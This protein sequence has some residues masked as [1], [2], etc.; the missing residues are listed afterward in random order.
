MAKD[1]VAK[2]SLVV[3]EKRSLREILEE[4]KQYEN[5]IK[6]HPD[7]L[8]RGQS[9]SNWS[10]E[11]SLARI[12][13]KKDLSHDKSLQLEREM[14]NKFSIS[15]SKL[16]ELKQT[17]DLSLSRFISQNPGQSIDFPGWFTVMQQYYAPTR[18]LDW[19]SSAMVAAYFACQVEETDGAI[20][21]ADY[22]KITNHSISWIADFNRDKKD[23]E[24]KS[25]TQLM[26][27]ESNMENIV[28]FMHAY[29][30]NERIE[31]QQGFYSICTNLLSDHRIEME[32]INALFKVV[33]PKDCK[34]KILSELYALNINAR[35][36]FPG[37]DGLGK[38]MKEF[39]N[40]WDPNSIIE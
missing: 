1:K 34:L 23:S 26:F 35:T 21:I 40:L 13:K 3:N 16:L 6:L 14:V 28:S 8:F 32:K 5:P 24:K 11:P 18:C 10:L 20:W 12:L 15:A 37:I 4:M 17:I 33:I 38:S 31:A 7:F 25:I 39:C 29:N 2:D 27:E 22:N 30:T 36:L 9:N 19:S